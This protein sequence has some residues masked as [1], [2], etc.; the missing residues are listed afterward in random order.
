VRARNGLR[1][2][3]YYTTKAASLILSS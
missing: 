1:P 3:R 2:A